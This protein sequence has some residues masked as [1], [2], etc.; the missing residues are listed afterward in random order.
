[1]RE[2]YV[3]RIR[4]KCVCV[5]GSHVLH[6]YRISIKRN[7]I[8]SLHKIPWDQ[9]MSATGFIVSKET[10]SQSASLA[11]KH[12]YFP[13]ITFRV[14]KRET[15]H[16]LYNQFSDIC[17]DRVWFSTFL[18]VNLRALGV[19]FMWCYG[20]N[21]EDSLQ[22]NREL[23]PCVVSTWVRIFKTS[24]DSKMFTITS[25]A[26]YRFTRKCLFN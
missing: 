2:Y 22:S 5:K 3:E 1:M 4:G 12:Y 16:E 8:F 21:S 17:M 18:Y 23:Q 11:I 6:A 19:S 25:F 9:L 20:K 10:T 13:V 14:Q 15:K 24:Y 26:F 7:L